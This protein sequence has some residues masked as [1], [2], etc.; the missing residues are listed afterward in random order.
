MLSDENAMNHPDYQE[1]NRIMDG[2]PFGYY[3]RLC[4]LRWLA[5]ATVGGGWLVDYDTFPLHKFESLPLPNEGKLTVH[6][7]SKSGGV[8]SMVSGTPEEWYRLA[9]AHVENAKAHSGESHWS[10]MKA[11]NDL[12]QT[13]DGAF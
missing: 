6:E 7:Y 11:L 4:F 3:D 8:P 2:L 12:F 13:S 9:K 5:M 1:M 10:D